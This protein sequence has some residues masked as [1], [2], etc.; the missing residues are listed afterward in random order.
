MNGPR[1]MCSCCEEV[2][3]DLGDPMCSQC[4]LGT[5]DDFDF[6][7]P[8]TSSCVGCGCTDLRA[9]SGGCSW[10]A[11]NHDDGTG[12]CSS[13]P[14]ALAAWRHQQAEPDALRRQALLAQMQQAQPIH[15]KSGALDL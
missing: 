8:A 6:D 4:W 13:C 5:D 9:C 15:T 1:L 3:V 2:E 7:R 14:M 11:V 12:V 10:L